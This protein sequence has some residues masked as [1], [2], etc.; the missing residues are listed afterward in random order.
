MLELANLPRQRSYGHDKRDTLTA[1]CRDCD[2]RFACNGGCP[3]D[4]FATS[5]HGEPGQQ[6][7]C[8]G[9]KTFF[10]H[11]RRPMETM[12]QLLRKHRAPAELMYI[13]AAEDHRRSRNAQCTCG[14]G[15]K[16][17]HCHGLESTARS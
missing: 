14:S 4:R 13:Y 2:V 7:L 1:T 8:P 6:Y 9:Y 3:K 5:T 16:W 11:V 12:V 15:K 17:K 10:A